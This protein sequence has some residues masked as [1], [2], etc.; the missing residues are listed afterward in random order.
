MKQ[1]PLAAYWTKQT[2]QTDQRVECNALNSSEVKGQIV[3]SLFGAVRGQESLATHR[4]AGY[5]KRT[6]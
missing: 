5:S 1:R 2:K 6:N 3:S 4:A